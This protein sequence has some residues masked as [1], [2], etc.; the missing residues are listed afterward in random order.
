MRDY[1]INPDGT[2]WGVFRSCS[3]VLPDGVRIREPL[4]VPMVMG[5]PPAEVLAALEAEREA[6]DG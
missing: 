4:N 2:W 6:S 1:G 3:Q 5:R